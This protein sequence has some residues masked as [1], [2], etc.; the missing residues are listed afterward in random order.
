VFGKQGSR[1]GFLTGVHRVHKGVR[2][3]IRAQRLDVTDDVRH[4]ELLVIRCQ[5]GERAA[6]DELIEQWHARLWQYARRLTGSDETADDVVQDVWL[7]VLRSIGRLRDGAKLRPWLFGIAR[8]VLMDRLRERY[9]APIESPLDLANL[10]A[11]APA[12][13]TPGDIEVMEDEIERLPVIDREVVV[14]FYFDG[15]SLNEIADIAGVPIGTVK[16]RLHRAR[17]TLRQHLIAQ[18]GKS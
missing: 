11:S 7:R 5:L 10:A 4:S 2:D 15:L 1:E 18:G 14:L 17:R 16:S 8:R 12:D 9:S 13:V 6:F 3:V